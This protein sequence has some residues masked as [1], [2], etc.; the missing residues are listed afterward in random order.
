M[1]E[2]RRFWLELLFVIALFAAAVTVRVYRLPEMPPGLWLD[3]AANGL[4]VMD[5]LEGHHSIFFERNK[6]REP[7]FFYLQALTVYWVGASPFGLRLAAAL[8]GAATV[9]TT[10]WMVRAL[11]GGDKLPARWVAGW[12]ALFLAFSYWHISLSRIGLRAITLPLLATLTFV[13]FWRAWGRLANPQRFPWFDLCMCGALTGLTLYT[14]T[15]SRF[16]P[17]LIVV[18][19]AAGF[20]LARSPAISRMRLVV[21]LGVI[22]LVALIVFAPL[23][24][25][26]LSHPDNF[27]GRATE[28][29]IFSELY[30]GNNP[31]AEF[32]K[33][34]W[35][36]AAMF[37]S[38]QDPNFRHNPAGRPVFDL[39]LTAWLVTGLLVALTQLR[40]SRYLFLLLWLIVL[41]LPA[42][43]TVE[44]VPHSLRGIGMTPAA[45]ILPV[46]GM[47]WAAKHL[48]GRW[49]S[50][51]FWLPL[52]FLLFS[53]F[54][55]VRDYFG[56][57]NDPEKAQI[58]FLTDYVDIGEAMAE[59]TD[60]ESIWI[61]PLSANYYLSEG[62]W[63]TFY[64]IEFYIRNR[65]AYGSVIADEGQAPQRLAELTRGR[66]LARMFRIRDAAFFDE[67]AFVFDDAKNLVEFLLSKHGQLTE[68]SDGR[69][70]G[71]PYK[72][73]AL[74]ANPDFRVNQN[75]TP[76]AIT[77]ADKVQLT[78]LDYG[79][80]RLDLVEP[81]NALA[82]KVSPAGHTLWLV[83]RWQAQTP[84]DYDL[85]TSLLLRDDQGH[86]AGQVDDLLVGDHYPVFRVWESGQ[87]AASYHILPILPGLPP[88]QYAVHLKVY[89]EA[90]GRIYPAYDDAGQPLGIEPVVGHVEITRSPTPQILT[91]DRPL[92]EHPQLAP[93][94]ELT[95]YNLGKD[96]AAPNE[97][98]PITLYWRATQTLDDDYLVALQLVDSQGVVVSEQ[99]RRPGNDAYPTT[100]W[101]AG[102]TIQ[103]W[104]DLP[105]PPDIP[106]GEYPLVVRLLAGGREV[107]RLPLAQVTVQGRA[108]QFTLPPLSLPVNATFD[109]TVQL[110][111]VDAPAV[112]SS[113]P[114]DTLTMTLGWQVQR[115]PATALVRFVHLLGEGGAPVA[116]Q[117]TIPCNGECPAVSW[118]AGEVL[119]DPVAL[120]L[121][122]GLAPGDYRLV[123][124]WYDPATFARPAAVDGRGGR[125]AD[126]VVMLPLT[127]TVTAE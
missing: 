41:A 38:A 113:A 36:T 8:A 67:F 31:L 106:H 76:R 73:F 126:D 111:G 89:E 97:L 71:L 99:I 70:I 53:S 58:F 1:S 96:V 118:L 26:F 115:T 4:D 6:G 50:V 109:E 22:G 82:E 92:P 19:M 121:P 88:G 87:A 124:G 33:S 122:A 60:P 57:W 55:G 72:V 15:A 25:Y 85:K 30:L 120:A 125:L 110:L 66:R 64:T 102:E 18:T 48:A 68:A 100:E 127:V 3:E 79:R 62:M 10:Y 54:T 84:V 75:P 21:A 11:F 61:L 78:S 112:I 32:L 74:P 27:M 12:S 29:S 35:R 34:T 86:L 80:T 42:L 51:V 77:F 63:P 14:Y 117:D 103:N 46:V 49:P 83:L 2:S 105:L 69:D 101:R 123:V 45:V 114:G 9:V 39:P 40:N 108:R 91:P 107:G 59:Q 20:L 90:T 23:G 16:V 104:H 28:I 24:S 13:F 56:A 93:G 7:L 116:Q 43:L 17:V 52:P 95:G 98:L 94:L 44:G 81:T 37:V 65:A 47:L 5:I 119:I